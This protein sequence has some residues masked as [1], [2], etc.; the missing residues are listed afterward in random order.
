[1]KTQ[2]I[3]SPPKADWDKLRQPLESGEK[4]FIEYLDEHLPKDWEIYIQP[5]LNGLCPDVV[6]LHPKIG[7]GV[8]EVKNW[9][10]NAMQYGIETKTNGK[11]H[12]Y[13][14]NHQGEKIS[15]VKKNPV[16]QL[17]LYRKEI[18][19]L[20]C[21]I[22][23][24]PKH[25]IVVSCGLVL[26]S[27]TQEN[28]ET[29]FQPIFQS[30]NRKI[31]A[32]NEEAQHNGYLIFSKESF[33][34]NLAEN[35]PSGIN[36][37]SSQFMNEIIAQQL[38]IW[39]IEPESSK[40]QREPIKYNPQQQKLIKER[41]ESGF[42][43]LKGPAGSGKSVVIAGRAA[44]L[45]RE[46]KSVLIVTFNITLLNYLQDLAVREYSKIR[47]DARWLNFHYQCRRLCYDASL[48]KEY[49]DL[50]HTAKKQG[51]S[52]PEN[53]KFCSLINQ[54]IEISE[55]EKYD[56]ILVDE[57]QDFNPKWWD[58]LK[59]LLAD[60]GEML[61]CADT[62]QDIY[63]SADLWTDD[64]MK[65]AGF[66]GAWAELK[67][68]YR[69]PDNLIPLANKFAEM[70]LP[71]EK[72]IKSESKNTHQDSFDFGIIE[73]STLIWENLKFL[74]SSSFF[75]IF[76]KFRNE[77]T[78]L[79]LSNSDITILVQTHEIGMNVCQALDSLNLK[80]IDIFS[81]DPAESRQKKMW[82]FKGDT[83][84][85]VCT[86][87]SFKGWEA[88]ALLVVWDKMHL[89]KEYALLYTAITRL[90]SGKSSILYVANTEPSLIEYSKLWKNI[91]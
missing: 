43:R 53:D 35:F 63:S 17:L 27:A 26:P 25:S 21:P 67:Q 78:K 73:E 46:Q 55:P 69:L 22:L 14:I 2:R 91:V 68:T 51:L 60:G 7:V 15:Y 61:L 90:K 47:T 24:R 6:I 5:H 11:V 85:K 84:I 4:Q 20:Y 83:K 32:P 89:H 16:D 23:S 76:K 88:K 79:Q 31:F 56:A 28:V 50:F 9:D 58:I 40:E 37:Y 36:R 45:L 49:A 33:S 52:F 44:T 80:H 39:L 48:D 30:R 34:K 59:K 77:I 75:D 13:A 64:V 38:R 66:K 3:I 86:V 42:R 62:T 18:L 81:N 1:M 10:F 19:D 57:G 41:T 12:L 8:F 70:F 54:A 72:V 82:F 29:L 74:D 71:Q 87:H 65:N